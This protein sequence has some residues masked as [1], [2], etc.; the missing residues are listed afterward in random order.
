M[1]APGAD[2]A[3][4]TYGKPYPMSSPVVIGFF[5]VRCTASRSQPETTPSR[6]STTCRAIW[7]PARASNASFCRNTA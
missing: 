1:S 5:G 4:A 6:F 3:H 2:T 7:G